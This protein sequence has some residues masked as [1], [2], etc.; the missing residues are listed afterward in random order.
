MLWLELTKDPR[1]GG[2]GWEFGKCLWSPTLK[3]NG[4]QWPYWSSLVSVKEGD[5]VIHLKKET[6]DWYFAGYGI[7]LADGFTTSERPPEPRENGFAIEFN[8]VDL[9]DY[10]P[11][12]NPIPLKSVFQEKDQQLREYFQTNKA[13]RKNI[14]KNLFYDEIEIY[15]RLQCH[16]GAYLTEVDEQL[17]SI[18]FG[19]D[20]SGRINDG[21][22]PIIDAKT[23]EILRTLKTLTGFTFL[24]QFMS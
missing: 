12:P 20:F 3:K 5:C 10:Q 8:R 23:G 1:H 21:K 14:R 9:K 24:V 6:H 19:V 16:N 7:A 22:L 13:K 17:A 15:D 2:L 4:G 18:L 11:F